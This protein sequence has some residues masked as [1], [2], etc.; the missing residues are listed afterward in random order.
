MPAEPTDPGFGENEVTQLLQL[1]Q[2]GDDGASAELL[3]IVY[4][5]LRLVAG[6]L[7]QA[8]RADHTLQPTALVHEAYVKLVGGVT[9][10]W[11]GREHFCAV[12]ARAMRQILVDHARARKAE[13]R[14]PGGQR[15]PL[16]MVNPPSGGEAIDP[17]VLDECLERLSG[18]DERGCRVVELRFFGGLTNE[19]VARVLDISL[20]TVER[21]WRRCRAWLETRLSER[22]T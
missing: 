16:T 3:P 7:F 12:A 9:D 1:V 2:Q 19:Q 13:K 11:R 6:R 15:V 14:D 17:I 20:P 18:M 21:D 4:E 22:A 10:E 8:E 5:Q